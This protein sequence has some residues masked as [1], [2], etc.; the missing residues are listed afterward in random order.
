MFRVILAR[1]RHHRGFEIIIHEWLLTMNREMAN[2][3][4]IIRLVVRRDSS[5]SLTKPGDV[6]KGVWNNLCESINSRERLKSQTKLQLLTSI[7]PIK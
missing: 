4:G 5:H 1:L 3:W 7:F 6:G 2:E